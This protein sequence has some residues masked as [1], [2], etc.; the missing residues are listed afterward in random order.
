[1]RAKAGLTTWTLRALAKRQFMSKATMVP[2][3][4]HD[5]EK[6]GVDLAMLAV[7][8]SKGLT[9]S[10]LREVVSSGVSLVRTY[11]EGYAAINATPEETASARACLG[12]GPDLDYYFTALGIGATH[13]ET[14]KAIIAGCYMPSY[15]EAL[16]DGDDH[17][18]AMRRCMGD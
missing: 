13:D 14:M 1:M 18:V 2:T 7:A 11:V 17:D 8:R 16:L 3:N 15:I 4:W 5:V 12:E 10:E 6:L 9:L